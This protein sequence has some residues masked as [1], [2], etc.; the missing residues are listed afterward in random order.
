ARD[1]LEIFNQC[2]AHRTA[3]E[4]HAVIGRSR[5]AADPGGRHVLVHEHAH[6]RFP[7]NSERLLGHTLFIPPAD[8]CVRR[9]ISSAAALGCIAY[10]RGEPAAPVPVRA[11]S[12][13]KELSWTPISSF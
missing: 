12:V 2:I 9:T 13:A 1:P 4:I 3:F 5:L 8:S 7:H 11:A 10:H 6:R